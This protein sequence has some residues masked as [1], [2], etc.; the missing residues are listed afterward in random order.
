MQWPPPSQLTLPPTHHSVHVHS[1]NAV[2]LAYTPEAFAVPGLASRLPAWAAAASPYLCFNGSFFLA[3]GYSLY[4]LVLEPLAGGS[5]TGEGGL[6]G[7]QGQAVC[8]GSG[9]CQAG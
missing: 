7:Q 8:Q 4:Y 9:H 1:A 3:A 5:W 6:W 2:W